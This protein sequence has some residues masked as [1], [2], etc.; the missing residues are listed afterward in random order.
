MRSGSSTNGVERGGSGGDKGTNTHVSRS[1]AGP[2]TLSK[3]AILCDPPNVRFAGAIAT[4][5]SLRVFALRRGLRRRRRLPRLDAKQSEELRARV[6]LALRTAGRAPRSLLVACD[7]ERAW[8]VWDG[9]PLELLPVKGDA[10]LVEATL[11]TLEIRARE[12]PPSRATDTA[13][14][15]TGPKPP[16]TPSPA[17]EVP[18]FVHMP[19]APQPERPVAAGGA[20]VGFSFEYLGSNLDPASGPRLDLGVGWGPWYVTLGESARFTS[21]SGEGLMLFDLG[22]GFGYGAPFTPGRLLG[23]SLTSGMEWFSIGSHSE[24]TGIA[25]L[26]L[27]LAP[28]LD[29]FAIAVGVDARVRFNPEYIGQT[30]DAAPPRWS[31]LLVIEGVLWAEPVRARPPAR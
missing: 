8:V 23:A 22:G 11:D 16:A 26:S 2:G 21:K 6:R 5:L 15:G 27:R 4:I 10:N 18:I 12:G 28:E 31:G 24:S 3:P 25:T 30:V 13:P 7:E 19:P 17:R 20:G 14:E 29:S 1:R 9:P